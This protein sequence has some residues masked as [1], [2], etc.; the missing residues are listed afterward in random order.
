MENGKRMAFRTGDQVRLTG[1]VTGASLDGESGTVV[2][3]AGEWVSMMIGTVL[4]IVTADN[5]R[6]LPSV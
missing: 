1:I 5:L 4:I 2:F 6:L 3:M